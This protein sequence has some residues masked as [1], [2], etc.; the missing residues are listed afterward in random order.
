MVQLGIHQRNYPLHTVAPYINW[1]YFF[2]AWGF[3][4]KFATLANQ[5]ECE[6]CRKLWISQFSIAEQPKANEALKLWKEAQRM[7]YLLDAQYHVHGCVNL[8]ECNSQGN[9]ILLYLPHEERARIPLLRQQSGTPPYLCLSDFIRPMELGRDVI[10]LFATTVDEDME[11]L[12]EGEDYKH[13]LVQTL[14]DR[15]AEAMAEKLH[16]EVRKDWW[17]FAPDEHFTPQ[18]LNDEKFQGI[19]PAVGYP[20]LPDISVN[21][22]LAELT[23]MESIGIHLTEN[24]MMKPHASVSGLMIAHPESHYFSIGKIGNDQLQDYARR[25]GYETDEIRRF[26]LNNI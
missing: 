11:R 25:R 3:A 4:P 23:Q 24:A 8:M 2:H 17:G 21:R 19:R 7:L 20:S 18:E 6:A 15:L 16:E 26:L 1:V 10:G 12:Y 13:L 9:D 22:L 14:A 5:C